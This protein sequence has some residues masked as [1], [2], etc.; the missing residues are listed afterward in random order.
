MFVMQ[1]C[2]KM[3]VA[4]FLVWIAITSFD[5]FVKRLANLCGV[6]YARDDAYQDYALYDPSFAPVKMNR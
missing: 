2:L 6:M 1:F 4:K 5:E 3:C